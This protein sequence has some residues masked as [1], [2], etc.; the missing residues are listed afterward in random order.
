MGLF[1]SNFIFILK[2]LVLR[3]YLFLFLYVYLSVCMQVCT[4]C[5]PRA[6]RGQRRVLQPLELEWQ[7]AADSPAWV[8]E[9]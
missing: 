1:E 4:I 9:T 6:H 3:I 2:L 7:V 8:L 5:I